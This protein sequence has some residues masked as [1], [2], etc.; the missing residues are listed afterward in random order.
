MKV[1]VCL[2]AGNGVV[3]TL[4]RKLTQSEVNHAFLAYPDTE[5]GGWWAA[6]I[7][8]RGVI[9][10]PAESV[11]CKTL[12][13]YE[14]NRDIS[15]ALPKTRQLIGSK[16]DFLGI[17]GFLCKLSVWR[18]FHKKIL[19]PIQNKGELFCSEMVTTFLKAADI[20]WAQR[21]DPASTSPGD[22]YNFLE[23]DSRFQTIPVPWKNG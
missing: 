10:V 4:I 3:G 16:Y 7:D 14:Y 19:N 9:L 20:S 8:Q 12:V 5:W 22:L 1:L 6:Q 15:Y 11:E 21:L 18:L 23:N 2:S 17:F 13:C